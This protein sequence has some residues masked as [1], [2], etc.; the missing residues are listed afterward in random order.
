[1]EKK[2]YNS[3]LTEVAKMTMTGVILTSPTGDWSMDNN[4]GHPGAP[5]RKTPVLGNDSVRVF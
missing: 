5:A 3:P 1:M 2:L 4:P